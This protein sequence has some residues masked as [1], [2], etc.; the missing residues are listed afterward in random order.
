[1]QC[2]GPQVPTRRPVIALAS[3]AVVFAFT[4]TL[5]A[6]AAYADPPPWAPAYGHN[7]KKKGKKK[8]KHQQ[9]DVVYRVPYGIDMGN[10]NRDLVGGVLGGAAGAAIGSTIGD[11]DGRI[12]AIIGG[13]ILGALVGGS[14]GRSMDQLDQN[15]VG[16]VL[17][18]AED[19]RT[20]AWNNPDADARY[21]VT[22]AGTYR[23]ALG[24][25]CREYTTNSIIG[26]KIQEVYGTACRQPD[27]S[28]KFGS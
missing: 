19:G 25:Y 2:P 16:Q 21:Q 8:N 15:C 26:G 11:G 22:P 5:V 13:T 27:G 28:W 14:I 12:A 3:A 10:C 23:N 4:V 6:E 1:M 7:A 24:N 18:H 9:P 17:E 20:V